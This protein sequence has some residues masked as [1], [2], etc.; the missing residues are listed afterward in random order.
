MYCSNESSTEGCY[1]EHKVNDTYYV[2]CRFEAQ[3]ALSEA[4]IRGKLSN[5]NGIHKHSDPQ[6]FPIIYDL[7]SM[8]V[9]ANEQKI[10][11]DKCEITLNSKVRQIHV[12]CDHA[13][14]PC[15]LSVSSDGKLLAT[16]E[17]SVHVTEITSD[18]FTVECNVCNTYIPI[19]CKANYVFMEKST[20]GIGVPSGGT[21]QACDALILCQ[22]VCFFL[23]RYFRR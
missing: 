7:E 14:P 9:Y 16:G 15:K 2:T 10:I 17:N 21:G 6:R 8:T 4:K 12:V 11:K 13:P 18:S 1:C 22:L 19:F 20:K 5:V 23:F 3:K